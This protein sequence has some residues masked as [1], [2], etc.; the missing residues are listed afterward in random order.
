MRKAPFGRRVPPSPSHHHRTEDVAVIVG[1]DSELSP[2]TR[3]PLRPGHRALM[4]AVSVSSSRG[5]RGESI[6]LCPPPF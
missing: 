5:G 2:E 3:V 6:N 1:R 4:Y